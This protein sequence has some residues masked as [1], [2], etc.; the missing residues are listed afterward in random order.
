MAHLRNLRRQKE[1]ERRAEI[2]R[3]WAGF[4]FFGCGS[5]PAKKH[6]DYSVRRRRRGGLFD[7]DEPVSRNPSPTAG[8]SG[9][10]GGNSMRPVTRNV[11]A[12][13]AA[14]AAPKRPATTQARP[15][16]GI[17]R[18]PKR[19]KYTIEGESSDDDY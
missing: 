13:P 10:Q 18:A 11:N 4:E 15:T 7:Y 3:N 1:N 14:A 9:A 19:V 8:G 12:P 2:Q 5:G 6:V 16:P 17:T